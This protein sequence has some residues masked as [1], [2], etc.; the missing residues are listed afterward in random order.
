MNSYDGNVYAAGPGPEDQLL[1][2]NTFGFGS[3][4]NIFFGLWRT[5]NIAIF[6]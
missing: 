3:N 1:D 4:R 5:Y 6:R 2:D